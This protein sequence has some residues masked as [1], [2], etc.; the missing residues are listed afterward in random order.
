MMYKKVLILPFIFMLI[1]SLLPKSQAAEMRIVIFVSDNEADSTLA[2]SVANIIEADAVIKVPWGVY[3][4]E[5]SAEVLKYAPDKVIIIGGPTAVSI[6]Y[7]KDFEEIGIPYERWYGKNRYETNLAVVQ[8]LEEE[9]PEEFSQIEAVYI[10]HGRDVLSMLMQK[11]ADKLP[12]TAKYKSIWVFTGDGYENLSLQVLDEIL[13]ASHRRPWVEII[14]TSRFVQLAHKEIP[15]PLFD[16]NTDAITSFL[17]E[18]GY[19]VSVGNYTQEVDFTVK[20]AIPGKDFVL[21]TLKLADNKTQTAEKF[22]DGLDRPEAKRRL[23]MAKE[24]IAKAWKLYSL[25]NYQEAYLLAVAANR[26]ADFVI[27]ISAKEW[28]KIIQGRPEIRLKKELLR[29]ET[30]VKVLRELGIDVSDIEDTISEIKAILNKSVLSPE[31]YK[32]LL[33]KIEE[34]KEELREVF[35]EEKRNIRHTPVEYVQ[36]RDEKDK[37]PRKSRP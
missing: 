3:N 32:N 21:E 5:Y 6:D 31:D 26:N 37:H 23:D 12:N 7:E 14:V 30:K 11:W 16:V 15:K 8:K 29:L 27:S 20:Y 2:E 35:I 13:K 33:E 25:G 36:E 18:R 17:R 22:L 9:F 10:V 19:E 24:Q 4:P 1:L 28:N 34:A